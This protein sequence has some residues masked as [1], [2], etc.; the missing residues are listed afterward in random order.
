VDFD[1]VT[2]AFDVLMMRRVDQSMRR[3]APVREPV[4]RSA[5]QPAFRSL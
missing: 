3:D 1:S 5:H 2:K 4:V